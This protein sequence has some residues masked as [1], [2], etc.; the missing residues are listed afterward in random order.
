MIFLNLSMNS[1]YYVIHSKYTSKDEVPSIIVD[2]LNDVMTGL[3]REYFGNYRLQ[4]DGSSYITYKY[5]SKNQRRMRQGGGYKG[6]YFYTKSKDGKSLVVNQLI[7]ELLSEV[8]TLNTSEL[9]SF[10]EKRIL[11]YVD[12]LHFRL[13]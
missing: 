10:S 4:V 8:E 13:V 12:Q 6:S 9:L 2:H 3:R 7:S 11:Y 1:L 5:N